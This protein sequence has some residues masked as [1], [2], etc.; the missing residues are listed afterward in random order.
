MCPTWEIRRTEN[1]VNDKVLFETYR[2]E[3]EC[4]K[5]EESIKTGYK[6]YLNVTEWL[7]T[8]KPLKE[9]LD[10]T[11]QDKCY[12]LNVYLPLYNKDEFYPKNTE[13]FIDNFNHTIVNVKPIRGYR[14]IFNR[15]YGHYY[16]GRH[17]THIETD[18][19][20]NLDT[21]KSLKELNMCVF[22][23]GYYP[24]NQSMWDRK[25]QI[26]SNMDHSIE[27]QPKQ[28]RNTSRQH[29]YSI[30]EMKAEY[31]EYL[32]YTNYVDEFRDAIE[33]CKSIV[34]KDN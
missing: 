31:N 13:E 3:S 8:N 5:I 1:I 26:R 17:F 10:F 18:N 23:C 4:K 7:I 29:F 15:S 34:H 30:E 25:L 33:F 27:Y 32:Q 22:W 16:I 2:I 20:Q 6:I 28:N 9:I 12:L 14:F 11:I 24:I 19:P 21:Y